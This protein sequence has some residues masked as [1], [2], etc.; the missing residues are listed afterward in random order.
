MKISQAGQNFSVKSKFV[1]SNKRKKEALEH[2]KGYQL[3]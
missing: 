2:S 1:Y 3:C